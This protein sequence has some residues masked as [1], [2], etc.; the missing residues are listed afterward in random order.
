MIYTVF[1]FELA[2]DTYSV[3][4]VVLTPYFYVFFFVICVM[5]QTFRQLQ[6]NS[7]SSQS[8]LHRKIQGELMRLAWT[9]SSS[10][11]LDALNFRHGLAF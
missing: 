1:Y 5:Q 2:D 8:S 4:V 9:G 3:L 11:S 6:L 7:R 10:S